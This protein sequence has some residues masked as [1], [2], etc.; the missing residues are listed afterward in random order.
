MLLCIGLLFIA[1]SVY[2]DPKI[3]TSEIGVIYLWYGRINKR[4]YIKIKIR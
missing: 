1:L 2:F 3:D 4:K